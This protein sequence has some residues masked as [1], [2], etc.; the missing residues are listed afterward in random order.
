MPR[1]LD[2]CGRRGIRAAVVISSGFAEESGEA[3]HA[4]D[5]ELRHIAERARHA[6]LRPQFGGPG[7]PAAA[8]RRHLQPGVSRSGAQPV[9]GDPARP[10]DRGQ[11]PERG[12]DLRLSEP[13][14]RPAVA[15]Q[16]SGQRRQS[17]DPRGARL[18]RLGARS[19]GRR[20]LPA[21]PRSDRP[22]GPFPRRRRQ[23]GRGRQAVDRRQGRP[24]R[25]PGA[26]RRPRI[27]ARSPMPGWSTTR[28]SAITGSSAARTS[29]TCSTSPPL[30]RFARCR[31]ATGSRSSPARAAVRCG[32]PT[33]CRR[34][35]SSCRCWRTRSSGAFSPCCRPTPRRR[36]RSTP[37]RRRST[38]S[39]M[40][41][42][43]RLCATRSGSTRS[44]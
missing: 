10:A 4:R 28:S 42:W 16:L 40:P 8:D 21:L 19:W 26:A 5:L 9:A 27:P 35:G 3:A 34:T 11:L 43:S 32:W 14:P 20:H 7:Q 25:L 39:A 41:G 38:R 31:A 22:P 1:T 6:D 33:S 17:D 12:V 13:R 37:P 18:C 44:C 23:G 15:L 36:T 24:L 29:T 30:F 2:E